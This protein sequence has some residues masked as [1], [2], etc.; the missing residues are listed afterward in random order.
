MADPL[1]MFQDEP[2]IGE[3][4]PEEIANALEAMG[5]IE[6]AQQIRQRIIG[7]AEEGIFSWGPPKPW[8]HT[9]HQIGYVAPEVPGSTVP[10]PVNHVSTLTPDQG[11]KNKRINVHLQRLN[12]FDYPGGNRHNV[13]LTFTA[14]NQ[15][16]N[17][18]EPVAFNQIYEVQEG[19][20]AGVVGYPIFIGLCVGT[21]GISFKFSTVNVKNSSDQNVLSFLDSAPFK[22]GLT[23]LATAQPVIKPFTEV[24]LGLT[25]MLFRRHENKLVQDFHLGLD[26]TPAA[27]GARLAQGTYIVVQV[28]D[29]DTIRWDEWQYDPTRGGVVEV[30]HPNRSLSTI[31]FNFTIFSVTEFKP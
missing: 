26:L 20:Q 5:D 16:P 11:L 17:A 22:S 21:L 10:R 23:L 13:L 24:A 27:Y 19:Q 7:A 2:V 8:Q 1:R 28:P 14:Q 3:L 25:K 15:I 6:E 4:Q 9:S 12:V 31:P 18:P 29:E 30:A